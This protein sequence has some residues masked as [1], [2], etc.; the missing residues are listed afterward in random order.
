MNASIR[1]VRWKEVTPPSRIVVIRF[2]ALGDMVITLPFLEAIKRNCPETNLHLL[3]RRDV[4]A[5]PESLPFI[6][7]VY[8]IGGSRSAFVHLLNALWTLRQLI[9]HRYDAVI[10]LQNNWISRLARRL[11]RPRAWCE[12]DK[13]SPMPASERTRQTIEALWDWNIKPTYRFVDGDHRSA[14]DNKILLENGW[15]NDH[16]LV[17]LNPAGYCS[18]REW[19]LTHYVAF[20]RKWQ[21]HINSMTQ[22]LLLLMPSHLQKA[23]YIKNELGD[24]CVDLTGKAGQADAFRIL[25]H[26]RLVLSEDSGLMHMA[27]TQGV[28]TL[29]LFSSSR[30]DWS[31]PQGDWSLCLDSSD[32]PC[33]PCQREVCKFG[34]NRCLTRYSPEFVLEKAKALVSGK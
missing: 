20:A 29:A 21:S 18:S 32:L 11:L 6:D 10:D 3:T 1:C 28:P 17:V 12:F 22:F 23:R 4:S 31:A 16:D 34:D 5:I 24:D 19:P 30:K 2:H 15:R 25:A 33:G 27:W 14:I 7:K 13:F 9:W 8:K 26:C